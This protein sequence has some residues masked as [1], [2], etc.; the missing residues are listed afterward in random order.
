M[1]KS[2]TWMIDRTAPKDLGLSIKHN[3]LEGEAFR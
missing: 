2:D 1:N 3:K